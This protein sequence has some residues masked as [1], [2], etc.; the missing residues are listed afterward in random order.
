ML[1]LD[2]APEGNFQQAQAD[3]L[4]NTIGE[5]EDRLT[6]AFY[7]KDPEKKVTNLLKVIN[8][9]SQLKKGSKRKS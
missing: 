5:L 2:L 3:M 4:A 6:M 8:N 1:P 9:S 7:E